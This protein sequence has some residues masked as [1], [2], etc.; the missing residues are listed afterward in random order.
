LNTLEED[1]A[2]GDPSLLAAR[3]PMCAQII[4]Y[5]MF[6]GKLKKPP[7]IGNFG[8]DPVSR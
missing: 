5:P 6:I 1:W 2:M 4:E 8:L 7:H 3:T